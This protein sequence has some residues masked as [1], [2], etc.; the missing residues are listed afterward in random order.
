MLTALP[1]QPLRAPRQVLLVDDDPHFVELARMLL[2]RDPELSIIAAAASGED[3][4][5]LCPVHKPDLVIVDVQMPGINGFET[6]RRLLGASPALNII[7]VSG[8]ED[9]TYRSLAE[10]IGALGFIVKKQL[11]PQAVKAML[12]PGLQP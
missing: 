2:A 10:S 4:V 11:S 3:A 5:A 8:Y 6:A 9:P 1:D 12:G 7:I